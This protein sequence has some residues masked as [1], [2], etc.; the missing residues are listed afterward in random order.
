[1]LYRS[2]LVDFSGFDINITE[3]AGKITFPFV[4]AQCTD[5]WFRSRCLGRRPGF[6][7][8]GLRRRGAR[9][10]EHQLF[11]QDVLTEGSRQCQS[12]RA[13]RNTRLLHG[14][15]ERCGQQEKPNHSDDYIHLFHWGK[16]VTC[17]Y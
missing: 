4:K 15:H 5:M 6:F 10:L 12:G 17:G 8:I 7:Q 13:E 2:D 9:Q 16:Q 14:Q 1:M 11:R 3:A